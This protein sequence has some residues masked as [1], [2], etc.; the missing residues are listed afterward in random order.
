[1]A[2]LFGLYCLN[3]IWLWYGNKVSSIANKG[4]GCLILAFLS[5]M[6]SNSFLIHAN[7]SVFQRSFR[8]SLWSKIIR[9]QI[10]LN[11]CSNIVAP[12]TSWALSWFQ[13]TSLSRIFNLKAALRYKMPVKASVSTLSTSLTWLYFVSHGLKICLLQVACSWL[14]IAQRFPSFYPWKKVWIMKMGFSQT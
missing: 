14:Y 10:N 5:F 8:V 1:M 3:P 12:I 11:L 9:Q 2:G 13:I 7:L 4:E 6:S